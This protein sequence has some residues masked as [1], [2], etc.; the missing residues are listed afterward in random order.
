MGGGGLVS[1]EHPPLTTVV[2]GEVEGVCGA[3]GG[4]P[5]KFS[6]QLMSPLRGGGR[7]GRESL[8]R[9]SPQTI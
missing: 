6:L 7:V 8:E 5:P 1:I 4:G 9:G 3:V 2:I